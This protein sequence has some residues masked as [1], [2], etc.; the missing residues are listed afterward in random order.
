MAIINVGRVVGLSAYELAV[1]NGYNKTEQEFV[2]ELLHSNPGRGV[3]FVDTLPEAAGEKVV[4]LKND[5]KSTMTP[6]EFDSTAVYTLNPKEFSGTLEAEFP[7][8]DDIDS[9]SLCAE[10]DRDFTIADLT[11]NNPVLSSAIKNIVIAP[12]DG[13]LPDNAVS[14]VWSEKAF[15]HELFGDIPGKTWLS[16]NGA[17]V[18]PIDLDIVKSIEFIF[19][20]GS[21]MRLANTLKTDLLNAFEI[22]TERVCKKGLYYTHDGTW[23]LLS[24]AKE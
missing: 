21:D 18:T 24:E 22:K 6:V 20:G 16:F 23:K 8:D 15:T 9:L 19:E 3:E 12:H 17:T 11:F 4:F 13:S 2:Y 1:K 5:Q 10:D 14:W 7:I